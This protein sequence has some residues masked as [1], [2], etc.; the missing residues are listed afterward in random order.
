MSKKFSKELICMYIYIFV[1]ERRNGYIALI[2]ISNRNYNMS[3]EIDNQSCTAFQSPGYNV[4]VK[5]KGL[6]SYRFEAFL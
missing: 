4:M 3:R 2:L 1:R 6:M 5:T